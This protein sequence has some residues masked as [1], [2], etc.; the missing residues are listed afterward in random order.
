MT[1]RLIESYQEIIAQ[2]FVDA[3]KSLGRQVGKD[4]YISLLR[5]KK[6]SK[7]I[8]GKYYQNEYYGIFSY[9]PINELSYILD[10]LIERGIIQTEA[11]GKVILL[12]SNKT[13]NEVKD[14][15]LN[16]L[17]CIMDNSINVLGKE[18]EELYSRLK[19]VR[20]TLSLKNKIPPYSVC[21]DKVLRDICIKKPKNEDA[22]DKISGVGEKFM[23]NYSNIFLKILQEYEV[24]K[25]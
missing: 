24:A 21:S 17:E 19:G 22:L 20:F 10:Y 4:M 13:I 5:G 18:D 14:A 15:E 8:N 16:F 1:N 9:L 2:I 3:V 23:S 7:I 25:V 11:K 6:N 12:S